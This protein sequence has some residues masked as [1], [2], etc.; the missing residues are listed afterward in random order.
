MAS[1][2]TGTPISH[3]RAL[4]DWEQEA[5]PT[6]LKLEKV[7]PGLLQRKVVSKKKI[8]KRI[9]EQKEFSTLLGILKAKPIEVFVGFLQALA[10]TFP[11]CET[12]RELVLKMRDSLER[13]YFSPG[14][15]AH[16]AAIQEVITRAAVE[17]RP[18]QSEVQ[19][20]VRE[21]LP[22]AGEPD[23]T[24]VA[25]SGIVSKDALTEESASQQPADF[26]MQPENVL[27][28]PIVADEP[29]ATT[30]FTS[31]ASDVS[32]TESEVVKSK[33]TGTSEAG[34]AQKLRGDITFDLS[35]CTYVE[36]CRSWQFTR[37]GIVREGGL[38]HCPAHGI[39]GHIP[40]TA[41]P[42][43]INNF[44]IG[45]KVF[46]W[47]D[48]RFPA[49]VEPCTAVVEFTLHPH[50]VF[51]E[52]IT[53]KI[54]HCV[55]GE[56][57]P[58]AFCLLTASDEHAPMFEFTDLGAKT[59]DS[60]SYHVVGKLRHFS[61]NVGARKKR[62]QSRSRTRSTG[63]ISKKKA[64]PN[65]KFRK[66]TTLADF[67]RQSSSLSSTGNSFESSCEDQGDSPLISQTSQEANTNCPTPSRHLPRQEA[68][69]TGSDHNGVLVS[70]QSSGDDGGCC[71]L[72][73]VQCMLHECNEGWET[74]FFL[75]CA[76]PTG[77]QVSYILKKKS[78]ACYFQFGG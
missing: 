3:N 15:E 47:G 32:S 71:E 31:V 30:R 55:G 61:R 21:E 36:P 40:A 66:K 46:M 20:S 69:D 10:D 22:T 70:Q 34:T 23:L 25:D 41:V 63:S 59:V 51:I 18:T 50:F 56:I 58:E 49:D 57:D 1:A 5:I 39:I 17:D 78:H 38:F 74:I 64:T 75:S 52:D 54:P 62:R 73:V 9:V 26:Q 14:S 13:I 42:P 45:M 12:H 53:V 77:M 48:F 2:H 4:V 29:V 35:A 76:H 8:G 33:A 24:K 67:K 43:W 60:D 44:E 16:R 28:L 68:L 72:C 27:D 37:K 19:S 11:E 6:L 7:M 65:L